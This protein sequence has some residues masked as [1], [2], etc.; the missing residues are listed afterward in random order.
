MNTDTIK[1]NNPQFYY[2]L[3][4]FKERYEVEIWNK[5]T[6]ATRCSLSDMSKKEIEKIVNFMVS[7]ALKNCE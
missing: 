2:A 1:A 6:I 3:L 7:E 4:E 5:F